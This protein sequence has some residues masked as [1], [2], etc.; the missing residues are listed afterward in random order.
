M[1]DMTMVNGLNSDQLFGTIDAVIDNPEI[2]KF[3][4]RA[5]N[6][7]VTGGHNRAS[8]KD[9][10]GALVED[11]SRSEPFLIEMDEPPVLLGDNKGAN[12][13]EVLLWALSGCL[14]TTMVL[15]AAVKGIKLNSIESTYEGYIDLHGLLGLDEDVRPGYQNITVTFKVDADAPRE[16]VEELIELA[17]RH[18][19]V[20][21]SINRPSP[22]TVTLEQ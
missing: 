6:T 13:V 17:Q 19:P 5:R 20:F 22:V 10:Y 1:A 15:H 14:T 16:A 9:F 3:H 4:F 8:A 12:P 7:W 21:N 18:S 11:E 2:A